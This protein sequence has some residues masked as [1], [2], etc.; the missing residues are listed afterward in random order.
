MY[1]YTCGKREREREREARG[2]GTIGRSAYYPLARLCQSLSVRSGDR[3]RARGTRSMNLGPR[4]VATN[5]QR[6]N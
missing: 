4:R 1:S 2:G 5:A 3:A 6:I